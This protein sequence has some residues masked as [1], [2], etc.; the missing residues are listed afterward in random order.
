M[1]KINNLLKQNVANIELPKINDSVE[2]LAF[3][4]K[5]LDNANKIRLLD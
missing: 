3:L 2:M 1:T 4:S 5:T